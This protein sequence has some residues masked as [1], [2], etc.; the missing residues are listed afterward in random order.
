MNASPIGMFDSGVGGLSILKA[1]RALLPSEFVFYVGDHANNPYG[2]KPSEF[3]RERGERI[4]NFLLSKGCKLVVVAC[5]TATIAGIDYF[6]QRFP[7]VPIVGV[8]PVVKTAAN[9]SKNKCFIVLSTHFTAKS[10]YQRDLIHRWAGDCSVTSLGSSLLVPLIEKGDTNSKEV[11][12]ELSRLFARVKHTPYDVIALGCTHYL[13]V[14]PAIRA[15]VGDG[16]EIIDSGGAVA[17]QVQHIVTVRNEASGGPGGETFYTTGEAEDAQI[18][19]QK[20]LGRN[21]SVAHVDI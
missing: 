4:I 2:E 14:R 10:H 7:T 1:V 11:I 13:F 15:I 19:F 16:I 21:I 17:R 9:R 12:G 8:V 3:I 5:N 18:V 6:R 20:L